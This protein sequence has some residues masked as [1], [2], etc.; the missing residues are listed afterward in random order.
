MKK[1]S[2]EE[3]V[4]LEKQYAKE[5]K[6]LHAKRQTEKYRRISKNSLLWSGIMPISH[7]NVR[8][9]NSGIFEVSNSKVCY[10]QIALIVHQYV[11][12]FEISMNMTLGVKIFHGFT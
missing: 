12:R 10:N 2:R 5:Q 11:F 8:L 4:D 3:I 7:I 9:S 1:Y 6:Q